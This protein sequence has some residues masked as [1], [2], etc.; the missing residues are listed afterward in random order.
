MQEGF[1]DG[2]RDRGR[3]DA[4]EAVRLLLEDDRDDV[5]GLSAGREGDEPGV[6]DVAE[7]GL[8]RSRLAGDL[9]ARGNLRRVPVPP[10][11]TSCIIWVS[12]AAVSGLIARPSVRGVVFLTVEPLGAMIF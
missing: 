8:G 1:E 5:R 12:S 7:P 9:D 3:D 2:L 6:V 11:T 10:W 4:A